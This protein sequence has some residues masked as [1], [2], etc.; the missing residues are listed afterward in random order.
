MATKT[1]RPP[2][3]P[4]RCYACQKPITRRNSAPVL[5]MP[6]VR[7]CTTCDEIV[8]ENGRRQERLARRAPR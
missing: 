5:F 8:I 1:N 3:R 6:H 2:K 4:L 7:L